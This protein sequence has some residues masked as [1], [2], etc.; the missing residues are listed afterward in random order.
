MVDPN[1]EWMTEEPLALLVFL[2]KILREVERMNIKFNPHST[3]KARDHIDNFYLQ[4]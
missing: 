1:L 4:M 3:V 2:N